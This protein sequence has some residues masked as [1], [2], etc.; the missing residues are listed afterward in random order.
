MSERIISE[1][2]Y[3]LLFVW[4]VVTIFLPGKVFAKDLGSA[5]GKI[6]EAKPNVY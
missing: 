5:M 1:V 3:F 2:A 4:D 6:G